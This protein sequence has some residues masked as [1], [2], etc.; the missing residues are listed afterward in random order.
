MNLKIKSERRCDR[1]TTAGSRDREAWVIQLMEDVLSLKRWNI[2]PS[3][4]VKVCFRDFDLNLSKKE[5]M[6][7]KYVLINRARNSLILI[8]RFLA[9]SRSARMRYWKSK[10]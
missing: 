1:R 6:F 2:H 9:S 10:S 7:L 4:V 5:I 3:K 8:C